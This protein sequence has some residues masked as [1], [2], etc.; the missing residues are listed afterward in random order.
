MDEKSV[1][2][3]HKDEDHLVRTWKELRDQ[4]GP[5]PGKVWSSV[6]TVERLHG[7]VKKLAKHSKG[8]T[9][10]GYQHT[11]RAALDVLSLEDLKR[12]GPVNWEIHSEEYVKRITFYID[13]LVHFINNEMVIRRCVNIILEHLGHNPDAIHLV[14]PHGLVD[15]KQLEMALVK[16]RSVHP[17][18]G[19]VEIKRALNSLERLRL[20]MAQ[21]QSLKVR[22]KVDWESLSADQEIAKELYGIAMKVKP[23]S[24]EKDRGLASSDI[25]LKDIDF[26][27]TSD[28]ML[29]KGMALVNGCTHTLPVQIRLSVYEH[30]LLHKEYERESLVESKQLVQQFRKDEWIPQQGFEGTTKERVLILIDTF[31]LRDQLAFLVGHR[32]EIFTNEGVLP[33]DGKMETHVL[34][35]ISKRGPNRFSEDGPVPYISYRQERF[36]PGVKKYVI[37]DI[38]IGIG[39]LWL[40]LSGNEPIKLE[41]NL[42]NLVRPLFIDDEDVFDWNA[43]VEYYTILADFAEAH[44]KTVLAEKLRELIVLLFLR[45]NDLKKRHLRSD[46]KIITYPDS[47]GIADKNKFLKYLRRNK[48]FFFVVGGVAILISV[49]QMLLDTKPPSPPQNPTLDQDDNDEDTELDKGNE[50]LKKIDELIHQLTLERE[51]VELDEED[52]LEYKGKLLELAKQTD[53]ESSMDYN[54][55]ISQMEEN[56]TSIKDIFIDRESELEGESEDLKQKKSGVK[57]KAQ[58]EQEQKKFEADLQSK[59]EELKATVQQAQ[60]ELE[61]KHKSMA[62]GLKIGG[63]ALAPMP[64]GHVKTSQ[65]V[66]DIP[67]DRLKGPPVIVYQPALPEMFERATMSTFHDGRWVKDPRLSQF[68]VIDSLETS[69][70]TR[71]IHANGFINNDSLAVMQPSRMG[72]IPARVLVDGKPVPHK[73][74]MNGLGE[75]LVVFD[76]P[77]KG[78]VSLMM[79]ERAQPSSLSSIEQSIYLD[80]PFKLKPPET[81]SIGMAECERIADPLTKAKAYERLVQTR[82]LYE[83]SKEAH[84]EFEKSKDKVNQLMWMGVGECEAANT[85]LAYLLRSGGIPSRYVFGYP[86]EIKEDIGVVYLGDGHAW[87]E[88]FIPGKGWVLLDGTSPKRSSN[89]Q[90]IMKISERMSSDKSSMDIP[91][92]VIKSTF[93]PEE[94][95]FYF[96]RILDEMVLLGGKSDFNK[97]HLKRLWDYAQEFS[98]EETYRAVL[99]TL[100][101]QENNLSPNFLDHYCYLLKTEWGSDAK[102]W[103]LLIKHII[104]QAKGGNNPLFYAIAGLHPYLQQVSRSGGD[105]RDANLFADLFKAD[106]IDEAKHSHTWDDEK[107]TMLLSSMHVIDEYSRSYVLTGFR[108]LVS[109]PEI[110]GTWCTFITQMHEYYRKT[111]QSYTG[112]TMEGILELLLK[113]TTGIEDADLINRVVSVLITNSSITSQIP[114]S[115]LDKVT[116]PDVI[117]RLQRY[118]DRLIPVIERDLCRKYSDA[119]DQLRRLTMYERDMP[120]AFHLLNDA[121]MEKFVKYILDYKQQHWRG[122]RGSPIEFYS[123]FLKIKEVQDVLVKNHELRKQARDLASDMVSDKDSDAEPISRVQVYENIFRAEYPKATGYEHKILACLEVY[124]VTKDVRNDLPMRDLV[125][126]VNFIDIDPQTHFS[127]PFSAPNIVQ[128]TQKLIEI[129]HDENLP[130]QFYS[131]P[132]S[133]IRG[134]GSTILDAHEFFLLMPKDFASKVLSDPQT[135]RQAMRLLI[136]AAASMAYIEDENQTVFCGSSAM[137]KLRLAATLPID[138]SILT[139]EINHMLGLLEQDFEKNLVWSSIVIHLIVWSGDHHLIEKQ[140]K[141]MIDENKVH[142][143]TAELTPL[144]LLINLDLPESKIRQYAGSALS[145]IEAAFGRTWIKHYHYHKVHFEKG[146]NGHIII[147]VL[148]SRMEQIIEDGDYA[149]GHNREFLDNVY[150]FIRHAENERLIRHPNIF[151]SI[152]GITGTRDDQNNKSNIFIGFIER[153]GSINDDTI[154][155]K[156]FEYRARWMNQLKLN[157]N[158]DP[159]ESEEY[160]RVQLFG[161]PMYHAHH[162]DVYDQK[163]VEDVGKRYAQGMLAT[164][165]RAP[166]KMV[167]LN[168]IGELNFHFHL[169]R[170]PSWEADMIGDY[171]RDAVAITAA[172]AKNASKFFEKADSLKF[173]PEDYLDCFAEIQKVKL[174][175]LTSASAHPELQNNLV[176][177]YENLDGLEMPIFDHLTEFEEQ[178]V[179]LKKVMTLK[180]ISQVN[181]K[182]FKVYETEVYNLGQH[183][184]AQDPDF[185]IYLLEEMTKP[186]AHVDL[187]IDIFIDFHSYR[188]LN[189][190]IDA[191][192]SGRQRLENGYLR[193][194]NGQ[195]AAV[196]VELTDHTLT[197]TAKKGQ[198]NGFGLGAL[199]I[200][201]VD[202]LTSMDGVAMFGSSPIPKR[203]RKLATRAFDTFFTEF[204]PTINENMHVRSDSLIA[205]KT[206]IRP[207]K[208]TP[209]KKSTR[210]EEKKVQIQKELERLHLLKFKTW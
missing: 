56:L 201:V 196:V 177:I 135:G 4:V 143:Y 126:A 159:P 142:Y 207:G 34:T 172:F 100:I 117:A 27:E 151:M 150:F 160:R 184:Y 179:L 133:Q 3:I 203:H 185:N 33:F 128:N 18:L 209:V 144:L 93:M 210:F 99:E 158:S 67:G 113:W 97:D 29:L 82:L 162:G 119:Q 96:L 50:A 49:C 12:E 200:L 148:M 168:A 125:K 87:T 69:K 145:A 122:D 1:N 78:V 89:Y 77:Q 21:R 193:L 176:K 111:Q 17:G 161:L 74:E 137:E 153:C 14:L 190:R 186:S 62:Q 13:E 79:A 188:L 7:I 167:F 41:A 116:D 130:N 46:G 178:L 36:M 109:G 139:G 31:S 182:V 173:A 53:R 61:K 108:Q 51:Q 198:E 2:V 32:L 63:Q 92:D 192:F 121:S 118:A 24:V 8:M 181:A 58:I 30:R 86:A 106:I 199:P 180:M 170:Y 104:K 25:H 85:V 205:Q 155:S 129:Y 195:K 208:T 42:K 134:I 149:A 57:T 131:R 19:E 164:D 140:F 91:L 37:K 146:P 154:L 48:K 175:V 10:E 71:V 138:R 187:S 206:K 165:G 88:A 101:F 169:D 52:Y 72:T 59:Q 98:L 16:I 23:T 38:R 127:H 66:I 191:E 94:Q 147:D 174:K 105:I 152:F 84:D 54:K 123:V 141:F 114:L 44:G 68:M 202:V 15:I 132:Y 6:R 189:G 43:Q 60:K 103:R 156:F 65:P 55:F 47:D 35:S 120:H 83:R 124:H 81:F 107:L 9:N 75:T 73:T 45:Y 112:T 22:S 76:S 80:I 39:G 28:I 26:R 166:F 115:V 204:G 70:T 102:S 64:S 171:S 5:D 157:W 110:L 197:L 194:T 163:Y 11:I 136:T 183:I 95:K 20:A 90:Q 40:I